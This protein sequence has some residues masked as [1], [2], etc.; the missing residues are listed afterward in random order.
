[1]SSYRPSVYRVRG[2]A[3][4]PGILRR[5]LQT[6]EGERRLAHPSVTRAPPVHAHTTYDISV[7]AGDFKELYKHFEA[8][9]RRDI[10]ADAVERLV[11]T[12]SQCRA[13]PE[14]VVDPRAALLALV[15]S[16]YRDRATA[17]LAEC[18]KRRRLV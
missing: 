6:R 1:M 15:E 14:T 17:L 13:R 7:C 8:L 3:P 9:I 5:H 4:K 10:A 16:P 11:A 2:H 18:A 12:P